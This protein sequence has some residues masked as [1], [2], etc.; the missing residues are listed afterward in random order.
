MA[1]VTQWTPF[2]AALNITANSAGVTRISATQYQVKINVSWETYWSGNETWYKMEASSGGKTVVLHDGKSGS[3]GSS[4]TLTGTYSISGNG[5]ASKTVTVTFKNSHPDKTDTYKTQNV[6][7]SVSVPAWTSYTVKYN[8]NGGAA[9]PSSQTKWK[10]QTL[11]LSTAKPTRTG[12]SF[13]GWATSASGS[14]AYAAGASYTANAAVTLY[15]VWKANTYT[16][17]YNANGGSGAPSNQ[18]KTYGT[19]LKLSST[20]P[21]RTNYN[22]LGWGTSASAT[23]ASYAAGAN[24][25]ANAAVTLYAVWQLAYTKPR[26]T[27]LSISRCDA[28]GTLTEEGTNARVSFN[29]ECDKAVTAIAIRWRTATDTNWTSASGISASGTSG[30]INKIVGSNALNNELIYSFQVEVKDSVDLSTQNTTLNGIKFAI[31][32]LAGGNGVAFGKAATVNGAMDVYMRTIIR[33]NE[34][35]SGTAESGQ[36]IVGDPNGYHIAMDNNEIMAKNNATTPGNITINYDGGNVGLGGSDS[37]IAINGN[38]YMKNGKALYAANSSGVDR[39]LVQLNASDQAVFGYG[40]YAN[41]EGASYFDGNS[42]NIRSKG[43]IAITSPTAGLTARQ[44]GVNKVLWSGAYFMTAGHTITLSENVSA[45]PNG[46]ALVFSCY[47][48]S[49]AQNYWFCDFFVPK[50]V[51][52]SHG[53]SGHEFIMAT[54]T[55]GTVAGKYLYISDDRIVGNDTND[56]T[57]T[58][59]GISYKNNQFVLRYVYGV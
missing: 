59:S 15:A 42:V 48:S 26:I 11:T 34:D 47:S 40:G 43:A 16:V 50:A 54:N 36:L 5:A 22:F 9:A 1:T 3:E 35:A 30:T 28:G 18:T 7:F 39:L 2:G 44:Y 45:Q 52:A 21:T 6:S 20:K 51:V 56:D 14:V 46:I 17:S 13:Q 10:D 8:A 49:A 32:F 57:G 19:T 53:G 4:G 55:F 25:T 24:Y 12:Y 41:N 58:A 31:D 23:T 29:W 38:A 27:G 37:K 33:G